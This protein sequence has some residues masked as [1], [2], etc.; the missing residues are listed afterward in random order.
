MYILMML[1]LVLAFS[2][3]RVS[4]LSDVELVTVARSRVNCAREVSRCVFDEHGNSAQVITFLFRYY[5]YLNLISDHFNHDC[6]QAIE[7]Q[8]RV[9]LALN[10]FERRRP[11]P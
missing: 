11:P 8:T 4:C 2:P 9:E 3:W 7:K 10:S 6:T 1:L 5:I